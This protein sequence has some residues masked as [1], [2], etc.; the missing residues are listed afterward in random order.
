MNKEQP[1]SRYS[2]DRSY[3]KLK[4]KQAKRESKLSQQGVPVSQTLP[5]PPLASA[6]FEE[7]QRASLEKAKA[8]RRKIEEGRAFSAQDRELMRRLVA[9]LEEN[10]AAL[11][12]AYDLEPTR[13]TSAAEEEEASEAPEQGSESAPEA[14]A[15]SEEAPELGASEPS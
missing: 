11:Q 13:L 4:E 6:T 10:T 15:S 1:L 12:Q 8:R 2:R 7:A 5:G 9:A 3:L 14:S